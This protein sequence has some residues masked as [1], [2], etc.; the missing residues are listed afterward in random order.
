MIAI[1]KGRI[2]TPGDGVVPARITFRWINVYHSTTACVG[3]KV[4]DM[5]RFFAVVAVLG[6]CLPV[7]FN[8]A[9]VEVAGLYEAA[10]PVAGQ[11]A[12]ERA[13]AIRAAL[14][15]VL[16]KINGSAEVL[17]NPVLRPL[18]DQAGQWVQRYQYRAAPPPTAA[19][20]EIPPGAEQPAPPAVPTQ[21]LWVAFDRQIIN[22]RLAEAALP[23]WGVNRP[24]TLLWLAVEEGSERY[25]VGGDNRPDLQGVIRGEA[26]RRGL[27]LSMP[28]L[29]LQDQRSLS[30][31]DVW[32]DFSDVIFQ[33]SD[34]YQP[35]A[36]L[37]G[38]VFAV[39]GDRWQGHWTLYHRGSEI[40]WDAPS[41]AQ[42]EA[43]AA[44]V[45]GAARQFAQRY[46][47]ILTPDAADSVVLA[48][49][50]VASLKDYARA[51]KYLQSLDPVASVQIAQVDG[52]QVRYR[53]KVR[54]KPQALAQTIAWGKT[55]IPVDAGND[56]AS[57]GQT[58]GG[59]GAGGFDNPQYRYRIVP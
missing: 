21:L 47:L 2:V 59:Q 9:A 36:V 18:L 30:V 32:G 22:Q 28:L 24:R 53:L 50:N 49:E 7:S 56:A 39:G 58:G 52:E 8:V 55:L 15:E 54:G 16:V 43:A 42:A 29:D 33:A 26:R 13:T 35:D 17:E 31:A 20:A 23:M 37:V 57:G 25:V 12:A 4:K 11:G 6:A 51:L 45:D 19:P 40:T 3:P 34:R 14:A 5:R 41:G 48:I 1:Y 38:R 10:V 27:P 44:G 46:A